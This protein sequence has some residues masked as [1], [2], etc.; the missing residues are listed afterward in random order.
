MGAR[1]M[2]AI[3]P[4]VHGIDQIMPG[5]DLVLSGKR[6]IH[7]EYLANGNDHH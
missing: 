1:S 5:S 4:L 7:R 6:F 2:I 3:G